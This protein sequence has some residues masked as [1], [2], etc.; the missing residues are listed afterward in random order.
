MAGSSILT[1]RTL[2]WVQEKGL[3]S[4]PTLTALTAQGYKQ[5]TAIQLLAIPELLAKKDTFLHARTG[6]GKTLGFLLPAL[7][8]LRAMGFKKSHGVGALVISPTRE[9]A[10]QIAQ[11]LKPLAEAHDFS[12]LT[13]IGG[14]KLKEEE[15]KDGCMI[16][17]G[18]P[19]RLTEILTAPEP[20]FRVTKL[21]I[22]ILDEADKLFDD[23][24]HT[25]YLRM[26]CKCLPLEKMQKVLVSATV[27]QKCL[28]LA[29]QILKTEFSYI[30][31]EKKV[32]P[33]TKQIKQ[34]YLLV[35]TTER[36]PMLV[37]VLRTLK[38]KKA[39]VFF[40]SCHSVKFHHEVLK[41]FGLPVLYCVGQEK[42]S[43]RS[44][45]YTK[46]VEMERG[47][48]LTTGMAERGWDIPGVQWIV[49]YDPP[50]KPEDYIHRIGRTGRGEGQTGQALLFLRPEEE[51]FIAV[52]KGMK[53]EIDQLEFQGDFNDIQEQLFSLISDGLD[54]RQSAK[55]A[56]KKFVRAY[57]CH[58][59]K[60][61]FNIQTLDLNQV[62]RAFGFT[63]PPL[64]LGKLT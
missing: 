23:S 63:K 20:E 55:M 24:M 50:H 31:S 11:V 14:K 15:K 58:K 22:L 35:S 54:I 30:T 36:V 47:I 5:L 43:Q 57:Q 48:L 26:I 52:L 10:L 18:T 42:Q 16:M 44:N 25:E 6:S 56:Y 62:C 21:K 32:S 12:S 8:R 19:G 41:H 13:L 64:E 28:K 3:C 1:N 33:T 46:F 49:Q 38:K 29:K 9:L 39:I 37:T 7:E 61:I 53:V 2:E 45:M 34:S 40:N 59:L 51:K 27:N 17:V 60:K 4:E